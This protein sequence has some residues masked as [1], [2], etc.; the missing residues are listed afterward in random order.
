MVATTQPGH[1]YTFRGVVTLDK[2]STNLS[3]TLVCFCHTATVSL[4]H[5]PPPCRGLHPH[6]SR[7]SVADQPAPTP[8]LLRVPLLWH[9][10]TVC[11]QAREQGKAVEAAMACRG[12]AAGHTG[13]RPGEEDSALVTQQDRCDQ[14]V[15]LGD[16]RVAGTH[17]AQDTQGSGHPCLLGCVVTFPS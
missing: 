5:C 6:T 3:S 15:R 14:V 2:F 11:T 10:A 7:T 17:K 12:G 9:C 16:T 4:P 1:L 8:V 13:T